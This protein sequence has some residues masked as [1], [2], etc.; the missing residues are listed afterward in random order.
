MTTLLTVASVDTDI[1]SVGEAWIQKNEGGYLFPKLPV[2]MVKTVRSGFTGVVNYRLAPLDT[3]MMKGKLG[4]WRPGQDKRPARGF[5]EEAKSFQVE[6]RDLEP[7]SRDLDS[8][9]HR[10]AFLENQVV[11]GM[12]SM[13][14]QGVDN[15]LNDYLT[16]TSNFGSA[17]TFTGSAALDDP[18]DHAA[19][20]PLADILE[21]LRPLRKYA[22]R[23]GYRLVMLV[24]EFV[25]EVL[26]QHPDF[27]GGP[28]R[29]GSS[30]VNG[31]GRAAILTQQEL[32]NILQS[33][34]RVDEVII[35]SGVTDTVERGQTSALRNIHNGLL[36]F[37]VVAANRSYDLRSQDSTDA[38]DGALVVGVGEAEGDTPGPQVR[39]TEDKRKLV[40]FF[41]AEMT[42]GFYT[43]RGST[44]GF[45]YTSSG[46]GGVFTTLPA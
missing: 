6:G 21:D 20:Q 39:A 29:D 11:E 41:D 35:A 13:F 33:K 40:E 45:F 26:C 3:F 36:W 9:G 19:Q 16:N 31:I 5:S 42:F 10:M 44:M 37:G 12:L 34:L 27:T 23:P 43:P 30:A 25:A 24:D 1:K 15:E 28:Y 7:I 14:M 4:K 18:S 17:R 8:S 38:P 2:A 46:A 32:I 22:T